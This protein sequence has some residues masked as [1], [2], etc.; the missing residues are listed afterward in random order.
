MRFLYPFL[1]LIGL[2][3]AD[4]SFAQ[5]DC[6]PVERPEE[7]LVIHANSDPD[8]LHPWNDYSNMRSTVFYYTQRQLLIFD[9]ASMTYVPVLLAELPTVSEDGLRID[10]RLRSGLTWDDGSDV[11]GRDL[12]FTLFVA[13]SPLS[14]NDIIRS[15]YDDI[16]KVTVDKK[17]QLKFSIHLNKPIANVLGLTTDLYIQ[18]EEHHDPYGISTAYEFSD[19]RKE[20]FREGAGKRLRALFNR[21][22]N[23]DNSM[24]PDSLKGLGPYYVS[25][26]DNHSFIELRRKEKWSGKAMGDFGVA[27]PER[28][29]FQRMHKEDIEEYLEAGKLDLSTEFGRDLLKTY[30]DNPCIQGQYNLYPTTDYSYLYMAMNMRPDSTRIPFFSDVRVRRAITLS[31]PYEQIM[32]S[33]ATRHAVRQNTQVSPLKTYYRKDLKTPAQDLQKAASLLSEAGWNDLDGDSI[34]DLIIQGD[35]IAFRFKLHFFKSSESNTKLAGMI[36]DALLEIGVEMDTIGMVFRDLYSAADERNFDATMGVWGGGGEYTSPSRLWSTGGANN[37][38]SFG[39]EESDALIDSIEDS[40][41][42][43]TRNALIG[44]LQEMIYEEQ[45]YVFLYTT[46]SSIVVHKRLGDNKPASGKYP[47]PLHRIEPGKFR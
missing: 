30:A 7:V 28:I 22:N 12:R 42:P 13:M 15:V 23:P 32:D 10:Y 27:L 29:V 44:E 43:E 47:L 26:W 33:I 40:W 35:T 5:D 46:F 36:K 11:T 1:I 34:R 45:P 39:S 38:A 19:L 37:F 25:V 24:L 8:G 18:Q 20:G 2:L 4:A 17:D 21:I 14:Q 16:E 3:L 6:D 31:M 41:I 9:D